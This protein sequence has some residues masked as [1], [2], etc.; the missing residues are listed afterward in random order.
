MQ[1]TGADNETATLHR[2]VK[3]NEKATPGR[4]F[5]LRPNGRTVT[6]LDSDGNV[7][8]SIMRYRAKG[9]CL[10]TNILSPADLADGRIFEYV[11]TDQLPDDHANLPGKQ[12]LILKGVDKG[13]MNQMVVSFQLQELVDGDKLIPGEVYLIQWLGKSDTSEGRSVNKFH[14][15]PVEVYTDEAGEES[16]E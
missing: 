5:A 10:T 12:V 16:G 9:E 13:D 8:V 2:R 14:V 1:L 3:A 4:S 6:A 15:Q 11:R 7:G